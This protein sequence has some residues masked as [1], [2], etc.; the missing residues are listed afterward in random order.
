[1]AVSSAAEVQRLTTVN[2]FI[3]LKIRASVKRSLAMFID[4]LEKH[5][6][7]TPAHKV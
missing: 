2:I 6:E 3:N 5:K 7:D 4:L 1:M